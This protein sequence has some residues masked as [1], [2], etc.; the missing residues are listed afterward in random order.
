MNR[1]PDSS[2]KGRKREIPR[3]W[4]WF[5]WFCAVMG[6]LSA[7]LYCLSALQAQRIGDLPRVGASAFQSTAPGTDV[8]ITGVLE[9]NRVHTSLDLVAY[10]RQRWDVDRD[11]NDWKGRWKT[12]DTVLPALRIS[13]DGEQVFAH[14][15]LLLGCESNVVHRSTAFRVR[16]QPEAIH[17]A[18]SV[19]RHR[20]APPR[21]TG[22]G[23]RPLLTYRHQLRFATPATSAASAAV[24]SSR[25]CSTLASPLIWHLLLRKGP[26]AHRAHRKT[27]AAWWR[28]RRIPAAAL[29]AESP[30]GRAAS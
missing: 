4:L 19:R 2:S 7:F 15:P 16:G 30:A 21:R 20:T 6:L 17:S 14:R 13:V 25:R 9:R 22:A 24:S 23:A 11:D 29:G 10:R 26:A 5:I 8:V 18:N 12:L 27:L 1:K 28:S 3:I